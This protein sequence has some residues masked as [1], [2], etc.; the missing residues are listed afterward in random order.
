MVIPNPNHMANNDWFNRRYL[1]SIDNIRLW[2]EN[3]RLNPEEKHVTLAD[4]VEDITEDDNDRRNFLELVKSIATNGFIPA[5]PIVV[6]QDT[7]N[8]KFYVAEGNRRILALKLLRDP[9]R[10]PKKIRAS[11]R[12]YAKQWSRINKIYINIA[13][14][15]DDAEWYINQR[16]STSTLQRKW[17]RL[18]QQR[19]VES[20]YVKYGEDYNLLAQKTNMSLG[21]IEAFIRDIKLIG[22]VKEPEVKELLTADEFKAATSHQFPMTVLERF[23]DTTRVREEWGVKFEGTSVKLDNRK[24]FLAAFACLIKNIVSPEPKI[25]ID[26]RTITSNIDGILMALPKVHKEES[27]PFSVETKKKLEEGTPVPAA[28][29]P[30]K[31]KVIKKGDPDRPHLVLS[32]YSLN[33]D[34]YRL[35][36]L[37]NELKELPTQKYVSIAAVSVRVFLDLAVLEYI[38]SEGLDTAI[39]AK[40]SGLLK[41]IELNKRLTFLAEQTGFKGTPLSTTIARLTNAKSDFSLDVLNGYI[42]G[43][44]TAYLNRNFLNRFWD[45]MFP[46]IRKLLVV[47]EVESDS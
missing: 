38:T 1:R 4:F 46:L 9:D 45:F 21:E 6:W 30:R 16:N 3:P 41:N 29:S 35:E 2:N 47:D 43:K 24:S 37:F 17:S 44:E 22:L 18:Q 27:A 11:I 19:W 20:L 13:P 25:K 39:C 14:T 10:A 12:S 31:K 28:P 23:F 26:T 36:H 15:L 34:N 40:H 42:H 5:E 8:N 32:C 7:N 33:N